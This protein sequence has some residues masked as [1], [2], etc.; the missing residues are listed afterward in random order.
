V[1][2]AFYD[3]GRFYDTGDAR[4]TGQSSVQASS[5]GLGVAMPVRIGLVRF[6]FAKPSDDNQRTQ[7]FQFDAR[8][9]WK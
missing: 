8:A 3:R 2:S 7:R 9:N 6:I 4:A 1:L 5:Y